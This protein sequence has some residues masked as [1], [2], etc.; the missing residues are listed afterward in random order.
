MQPISHVGEHSS[1]AVETP[2]LQLSL[3]PITHVGEHSLDADRTAFPQQTVQIA[4][5]GPLLFAFSIVLP[6]LL[7]F[8]KHNG[9][10]LSLS[11][12]A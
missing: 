7:W 11:S 8:R 5:L 12:T 2:V 3:Q 4:L 6:F 1:A 9:L 10:S